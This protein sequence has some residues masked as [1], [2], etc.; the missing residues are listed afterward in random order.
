M[1]WRIAELPKLPGSDVLER[2]EAEGWQIHQIVGPHPKSGM[3]YVYLWRA[4]IEASH[5]PADKAGVMR[6]V[7]RP[8]RKA[9]R[10][11]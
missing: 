4:I 9:R 6:P 11:N 5:V 8:N 3:I 7:A 1:P 10:L 2:F